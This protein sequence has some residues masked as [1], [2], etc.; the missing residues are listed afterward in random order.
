MTPAVSTRK[1][2]RTKTQSENI[3]PS[4]TVTPVLGDPAADCDVSDM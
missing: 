1:Q 3:A 2:R 4:K